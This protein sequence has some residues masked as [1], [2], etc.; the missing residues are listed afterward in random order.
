MATD[1]LKEKGG[2][3]AGDLI[4]EAAAKLGASD[5]VQQG[6]ASVGSGIVGNFASNLSQGIQ[7]APPQTLSSLGNA[8]VG[9]GV[10]AIGSSERAAIQSALYQHAMQRADQFL[11]TVS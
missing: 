6:L 7:Q 1:F 9:A 4:T 3:I 10:S 2:Q 11:Q 8:V 5:A